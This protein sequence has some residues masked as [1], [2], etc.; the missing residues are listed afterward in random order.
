[1]AKEFWDQRYVA[2]ESVYGSEPN[3]FFKQ[4][5]D[6]HKPGTVLLPAEGE[7]RNALYAAKKG[8]TVHAFDYSEVAR[9]K[10]LKAAGEQGLKI[11]YWNQ[12]IEDFRANQ[13]YDLVASIYVHLP[14]ALRKQYHQELIK[15]IRPGGYLLLEAFAKEQI[16]YKS[17]GPKDPAL[18]YDAPTLCNDFAFLHVLSCQQ[19]DLHLNEGPFHSGEAAV[20]RLTVQKI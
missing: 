18:L 6:N 8:W 4:F 17:G 2:N 7:G 15:S 1:M 12:S 16:D 10:A 11:V 13:Q 20:L 14:A 19:K 9:E 5:I 3:A